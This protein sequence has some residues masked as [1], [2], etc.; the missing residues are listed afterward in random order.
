MPLI[1]GFV[2]SNLSESLDR[3]DKPGDPNGLPDPEV[4]SDF[5]LLVLPPITLPSLMEDELP[6]PAGGPNPENDTS[7]LLSLPAPVALLNPEG[8]PGCPDILEAFPPRDDV[9]PPGPLDCPGIPPPIPGDE[10]ILPGP[11]DWPDIS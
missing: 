2:E 5:S 8:D 3:P 11:L 10:L 6:N 9:N 7:L 1:P 4:A